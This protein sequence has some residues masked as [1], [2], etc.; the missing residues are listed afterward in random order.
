MHK[1]VQELE[2]CESQCSP[3]NLGLVSER[4][5]M[6][7]TLCATMLVENMDYGDNFAVPSVLIYTYI[8]FLLHF[9]F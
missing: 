8:F 1:C 7:A 5:C 3:L 4:H 6:I 2:L 9:V